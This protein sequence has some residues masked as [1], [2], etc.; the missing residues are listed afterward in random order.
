ME[1]RDAKNEK[2]RCKHEMANV[3]LF[4]SAIISYIDASTLFYTRKSFGRRT[5]EKYEDVEH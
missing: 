2:S 5:L 3:S 4:L 1:S